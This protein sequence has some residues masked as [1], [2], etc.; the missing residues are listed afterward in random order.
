MNVGGGGKLGETTDIRGG[1]LG[2]TIDIH[3]TSRTFLRAKE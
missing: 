3:G 1:K 2:E